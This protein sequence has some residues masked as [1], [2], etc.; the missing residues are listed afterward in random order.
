MN[1]LLQPGF[2]DYS[3][4]KVFGKSL[5][6]NEYKMIKEA[7]QY[8]IPREYIVQLFTMRDKILRN[9]ED[10][11]KILQYL[12]HD[13]PQKSVIQCEFFESASDVPD[14]ADVDKT[15]KT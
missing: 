3:T 2:L 10:P 8:G 13:L 9:C 14:S 6:Q 7:F 15:C 11:I 12:C 1:L 4:L 5:F